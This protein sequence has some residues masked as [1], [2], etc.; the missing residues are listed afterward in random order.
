MAVTTAAV[1]G[2]AAAVKGAYDANKASK[3]AKKI[4]AQAAN[5]PAPQVNI[6]QTDAQARQT[7]IQNAIDSAALERQFNPGAAELRQGGLQALMASLNAG[8]PE[9][10]AL[11]SRIMVQAG[12]PLSVGPA[13]QYDSALTRQA[14]EAASRD[15]SMG[16]Q[17]PQDV[18][19]LVAR[20]ALAKSGSVTGRLALGGDITAR[21]L[22]LT[23]LDL[24]NRRLQNAASLGAQE[25][26]IASGNAQLRAGNDAQAL[27]AQQYGRQNLFDSASF[28]DQINSGNFARS[29]AAAQLGQNIAQP[30]SGLDPSAIANLA[31][32]NVNAQAG[33]DQQ[34][35]ALQVGAAN[36]RAAAGAQ[37]M[38]TGLG[39][40]SQYNRQP[41]TPTT[42]TGSGGAPAPASGLATQPYFFCWVARAA[43]GEDNPEWMNFRDWLLGSGRTEFVE[44]YRHNGEAVAREIAG[45]PNVKQLIRHLMD[46]AKGG[47]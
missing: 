42:Y 15:L 28:F 7:A 35:A 33:K 14:V 8:T 29:L 30:Q 11:G 13:Q 2:A 31:I 45:S 26:G 41:S 23:S 40:V 19:N 25:A 32:G 20:N 39:F 22:G 10:D 6:A 37:L 46:A 43:Y 5:T 1:I 3:D 38:G 16:G 24:Y 27:A 34:T 18:R 47:R 17:L 36:A 9:R 12:Q 44:F 21:D 4:A